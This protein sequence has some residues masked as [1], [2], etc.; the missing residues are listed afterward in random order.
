MKIQK[1]LTSELGIP[2]S[3]KDVKIF[4]GD[5]HI[6]P[7]LARIKGLTFTHQTSKVTQYIQLG[8][9]LWKKLYLSLN[10][11]FKLIFKCSSG[12]SCFNQKP[13]FNNS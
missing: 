13:I 1:E 9:E 8:A 2:K 6:K 4:I 5:K 12:V 3:Y 10:I 7:S 11:I